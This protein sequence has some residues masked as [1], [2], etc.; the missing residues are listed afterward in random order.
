MIL[1][2]NFSFDIFQSQSMCFFFIYDMASITRVMFDSNAGVFNATQNL[3]IIQ[4]HYI[5]WV[6]NR[7]KTS[8]IV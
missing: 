6:M 2:Y 3:M 8:D 7:S 1:V 4:K 5:V